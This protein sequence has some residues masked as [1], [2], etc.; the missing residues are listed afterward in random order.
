M[1]RL[2]IVD[3]HANVRQYL[4]DYLQS[5]P[6]LSV[7]AEGSNGAKAAQIATEVAPD[8][9]LMDLVMP[10]QNGMDALAAIRSRAPHVPVLILS[11]YPEEFYALMLLQRG[12]AG[13][14]QKNCEPELIVEAIRTVAAGR[15]YVTPQLARDLMAKA[16]QGAAPFDPDAQATVAAALAHQLQCCAWPLALKPQANAGAA[17]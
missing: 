6:G 16:T 10:G 11:G 12:A 13:F 2:A 7:V 14:L 9:L 3:D 8:V 1:I 17:A 5:C 4:R 15:L